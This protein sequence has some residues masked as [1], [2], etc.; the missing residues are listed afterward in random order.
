MSFIF[1]PYLAA[2]TSLFV[3]QMSASLH[4]TDSS[5]ACSIN[6]SPLSIINLYTSASVLATRSM[7]C[8]CIDQHLSL[9]SS[10]QELRKLQLM[11]V[12]G[13]LYRNR[14][15]S[16]YHMCFADIN[17]HQIISVSFYNHPRYSSLTV[18]METSPLYTT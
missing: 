11:L 12:G 13:L 18:T 4:V 3:A 7:I 14:L 16:V 8:S 15:S 2:V 9:P 5:S 17:T 6:S 1:P 10:N